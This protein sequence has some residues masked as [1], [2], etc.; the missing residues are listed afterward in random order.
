VGGGKLNIELVGPDLLGWTLVLLMGERV[1][2]PA[3]MLDLSES[4]LKLPPV[5][6]ALK[7]D[8]NYSKLY[9]SWGCY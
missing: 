2:W 9:L 7:S 3:P 5:G 8:L 6:F 1:E 4:E